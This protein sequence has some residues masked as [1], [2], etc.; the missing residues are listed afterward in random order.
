MILVRAFQ[1]KTTTN[2]LTH[3]LV[4]AFQS[5]TTEVSAHQDCN[6]GVSNVGWAEVSVNMLARGL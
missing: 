6:R 1:N 3:T 4:R 5:I 2:F